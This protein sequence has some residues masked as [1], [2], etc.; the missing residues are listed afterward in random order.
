MWRIWQGSDMKI[1]KTRQNRLWIFD[2]VNHWTKLPRI[3]GQHLHQPEDCP[4]WPF[5]SN[6]ANLICPR[7]VQD[8][9]VNQQDSCPIQTKTQ[10]GLIHMGG[11]WQIRTVAHP[12]FGTNRGAWPADTILPQWWTCGGWVDPL[13]G[14]TFQ[15]KDHIL[16]LLNR[17]SNNLTNTNTRHRQ[18]CARTM[19]DLA[20]AGTG[21]RTIP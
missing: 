13:S 3:E 2:F 12:L 8:S 4:T 9:F 20:E 14:G 21:W 5:C 16:N 7:Y 11:Q 15:D 1:W 10:S 18:E 19:F 6:P 17:Q